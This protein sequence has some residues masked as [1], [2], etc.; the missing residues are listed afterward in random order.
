VTAQGQPLTRF[1]RAVK[2]GN[3]FLAEL[4]AK[5]CG[6]VPLPDALTLVTLYATEGSPKFDRAARRWLAR[7][8]LESDHLTLGGS[9]RR[10]RTRATTR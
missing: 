10:G 5:E 7:L 2:G 3:V 6:F 9:A 4:A 1:A 8:A